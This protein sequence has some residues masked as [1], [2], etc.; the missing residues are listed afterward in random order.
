[1]AN[2]GST[3]TVPAST[4]AANANGAGNQADTESLASV[5]DIIA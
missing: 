1:L 5:F 2:T 4:G 3:P